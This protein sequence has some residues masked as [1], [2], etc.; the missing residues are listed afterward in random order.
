MIFRASNAFLLWL[1]VLVSTTALAQ[2]TN[3][4]ELGRDALAKLPR[5]RWYN[6]EEGKIQPVTVPAET[7][8]PSSQPGSPPKPKKKR[9][10]NNWNWN[11]PSFGSLSFGSLL[12]YL[13][14]I[15]VLVF[16]VYVI[17]RSIRVGGASS[18][19]RRRKQDHPLEDTTTQ[20]DRVENLPFE[21]KKKDANLLDEAKRCFEAGNF[22]DAIVYLFSFQLVE[23]DKGHII[24]LTKGKTNG[25]Y[26]REM[27][28]HRPIRNILQQ[29]MNAFEDVFFGNHDL[30]AD[31][32]SSCWNQVSEFQRL[33]EG[34]RP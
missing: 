27:R 24:R 34:S 32:F 21:V 15:A 3:S 30:S 7:E 25:Q 16:L 29:T 13:F 5:T 14:L 4:V 6:E 28:Q 31:R 20:V 23:L 26:L 11:F 9:A 18:S 2:E 33:I 19:S 8:M 10:R 22:N 12:M 17:A 1:L